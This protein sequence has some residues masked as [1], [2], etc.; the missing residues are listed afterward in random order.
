MKGDIPLFDVAGLATDATSNGPLSGTSNDALGGIGTG[1]SGLKGPGNQNEEERLNYL[2]MPK[3]MDT[4]E[5]PIL[6]E[7]DEL[8]AHPETGAVLEKLQQQLDLVSAGKQPHARLDLDDLPSEAC[9]LLYQTL[10]EGE[11]ACLLEWG[12]DHRQCAGK[13]LRVQETVLAG[14]WWLQQVDA[15]Q[16]LEKQWLEVG[17]I[18]T[19]M[20]ADAFPAMTDQTFALQ[21]LPDGLIN[22]GPILIEL[23][24]KA[25]E[26]A[27]TPRTEPHVVNLSLLPFSPEDHACLNQRLGLGHV[28]I[29]SRG[30][31]NCRITATSVTGIWR[32]QYF[33]S[34]EQLILDTLEVINVP[35]VACAAQEDLEDSAERL[36]EIHDALQ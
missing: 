24:D 11:V 28:V 5:I 33:N 21:T 22:A 32:V 19:A 35:Q 34:T 31:G 30:Y 4:F 18:P 13:R 2:Q 29:L 6:P 17:T 1:L 7:V 23:M 26:H 15:E 16:Q 10:G 20:V 12:A 27:R 14:V 3:E 25:A 8:A 36:R 9:A